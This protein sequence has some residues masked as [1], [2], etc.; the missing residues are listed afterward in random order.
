MAH[1]SLVGAGL[2]LLLAAPA[3]AAEPITLQ[4]P[5]RCDLGETCVIQHYVDRDPTEGA[6]DY[7]CGTMTYDKH[8]GVDIRLPSLAA[9]KR[10]VDVLAAAPGRVLRVRDGM[11][12]I[13]VRRDGGKEAIEGQDCGNGVVI[14]H[15]DGWETQYCHMAKGSVRVKPGQTVAEG[16]PIGHVG[17]SGNTEFPHLH[18][19]VRHDGKV[20]DPFADG[21]STCGEEGRSLWAPV[22]AAKLNYHPGEVLNTGFAAGPVTMA[23]IEADTAARAPASDQPAMV[24]FVRA[25]GLRKGDVQRLIVTGPD[26]ATVVDNTDKP[27]D[28]NKAQALRFAGRKRPPAG[29]TAGVYTAHYTVSRDGK[30]VIEKTFAAEMPKS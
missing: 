24:V 4:W 20:V 26:G 23:E 18:I 17:L 8:S 5:V 29:W 3:L 13:S 27:L 10:G 30:V 22:L 12:D 19:T 15:R 9:E 6:S 7:R 16:D 2:A 14:A 11:A 25:I 1:S 28:A 21:A